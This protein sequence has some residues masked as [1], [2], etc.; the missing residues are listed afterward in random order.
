V[1]ACKTIAVLTMFVL[2]AAGCQPVATT[3]LPPAP[4]SAPSTST[5]VPT[6]SLSLVA[7][8]TPAPTPPSS[9]TPAPT[10]EAT[11][12]PW[13]PA[14]PEEPCVPSET[15]TCQVLF[16]GQTP[17]G[18]DV[19]IFAP[20]LVSI[21]EGKEYKI[22]ISP[23]L[24]EIFFTRR[25]PG[26][27]D[28]RLWY[29][30]LENGKLTMP[31]PAP[32]TYDVLETDACFTPDGNRLYYNS[33]RPLPGEE[34][35][36]RLPNVWFVDR[37]EAGWSEPQFVG[38]PLNDYQP[39]YFSFANDG[40]LYF[41]RSSPRGIYFAE[42][43]DGQYR[44][45]HRLPDEINDVRDVAHPAIAPDES[46]IVVDSAYEQGGRLV[47]S[48]YVSFKR[49]DGSWTKAVSMHD[50]LKA[51]EADVYAIPR[52]TP[53]GKYLFFE[54]YDRETDRSDIYWVRTDVIKKL[55][56]PMAPDPAAADLAATYPPDRL[57]IT[58][59]T[60]ARVENLLTFQGQNVSSVDLVFLPDGEHLASFGSDATYHVWDVDSGQEVRSL[61][62]GGG[63][64][65][66]A[67][68]SADGS[69]L[70]VEGP[71]HTIQV[72]DVRQPQSNGVESGQVVH[73]L[74]GHNGSVMSLAFSADGAL[75]A[76]ADSNGLIEVWEVGPGRELFSLRG[77]SSP[78]GALAFSADGSR[79]ASG[80]VEGS[81]AIKLWD[82]TSGQEVYT[83]DG[84]TDNVY[85]LAFSPDSSRLVSA[86]GD[87]TLRVWDV[88]SG[89]ELR[90]LRGHQGRIYSVAYSPDGMLLASGDFRG[91][92]K[93][94]DAESGTEVHS[95][96]AHT[97]LLEPL[98]F[99]ADGSLLASSS[100]DRTVKLWGVKK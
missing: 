48:L 8:E 46:Y 53:D 78:I 7:T 44:E 74:R 68:F 89:R 1:K 17:P 25:T 80:S 26:G 96:Q 65:Y 18:L 9:P 90:T 85:S 61:S 86:S 82:M 40:T 63:P 71:G 39:V 20:G 2:L 32:F 22:A 31:E 51:S 67:A 72:R 93:F 13:R 56:P 91:T 37:T 60:A 97:D 6:E 5:S 42:P 79:L 4:T 83:L 34:A 41:T 23:D 10:S 19:E 75:L 58:P 21:E 66:Y 64:V 16:L 57:P 15:R 73:S 99:S 50:A 30:R 3:P 33:A 69:R 54:K 24:R 12:E 84:H 35:A 49:P 94:W 28:D 29:S 76:T 38:P 95:L 88:A 77:H 43:E 59:A 92:I 45:A 27:R 70:A 36:S 87:R 52:I 98:V 100:F 47:G 55:G 11:T 14:L 62:P 81:T